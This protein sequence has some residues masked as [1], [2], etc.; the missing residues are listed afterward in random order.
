M[1]Q[2]VYF[3]LWSTVARVGVGVNGLITTLSDTI[4]C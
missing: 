2:L 4:V 1:E 3:Y